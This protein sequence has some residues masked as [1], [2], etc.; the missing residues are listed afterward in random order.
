MESKDGIKFTRLNNKILKADASVNNDFKYGIEDVRIVKYGEIYLL[1]GCGKIKPPF[2]GD[3]ADRVAIYSTED[4]EN[5]SYQGIINCFD[6]RNA[7]PFPEPLSNGDY[8]MFLP[9]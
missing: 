2:K 8:Y 4:F 3:N 9:F 7:V 6:S 1:V 5:I